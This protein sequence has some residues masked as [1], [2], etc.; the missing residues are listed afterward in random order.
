MY[1]RITFNILQ[2]NFSAAEKEHNDSE[3]SV[4]ARFNEETSD[5]Q[6]TYQCYI[7]QDNVRIGSGSD[8]YTEL[9]DSE[10]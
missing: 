4:T 7:E 9:S 10:D 6:I 8:S 1:L 3:N 5:P 2:P